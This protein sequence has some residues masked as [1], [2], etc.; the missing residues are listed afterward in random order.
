MHQFQCE[1]VD[2]NAHSYNV[3]VNTKNVCAPGGWTSRFHLI[4]RK[5]HVCTAAQVYVADLMNTTLNSM[6]L[7]SYFLVCW[8]RRAP[9]IKISGLARRG[10][11]FMPY[12]TSIRNI[13]TCV[14]N[15]N[16]FVLFLKNLKVQVHSRPSHQGTERP[17]L[18][19]KG[20]TRIC[21]LR[22]PYTLI[23]PLHSKGS[24]TL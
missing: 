24:L 7:L 10:S 17:L 19:M 21:G 11:C 18:K 2:S 15:N 9:V 4:Y 8:H 5:E 1:K 12:S 16:Y 23:G 20:A 6:W 3:K 14:P 13:V 22:A